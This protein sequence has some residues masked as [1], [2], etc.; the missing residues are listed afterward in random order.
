M[1]KRAALRWALLTIPAVVL[2][3]CR[4]S[5]SPAPSTE[6]RPPAQFLPVALRAGAPALAQRT[7]S[8]WA[9]YDQDREVAIFFRP[10]PGNSDSTEYLRFRV[11]ARSLLRDASGRTFSGSDSVLITIT[12]PDSGVFAA[13]FQPSGLRF[14]PSR[15]A[16]LKFELQERDDDLDRD[17]D[18]DDDDDDRFVN[19]SLWR[20]ERPGS[21][22]E[23]IASLVL[24]GLEEIEAE[25]TG[26]TG[27]A[28]AI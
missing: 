12:V 26:F 9:R 10:Q 20:Q 13:D 7:V 4:E 14:D 3:A 19:L 11:P 22:W 27:Y 23:K 15:P 21:V 5:T 6:T 8:F 18:D 16:R 2:L 17:G 1:R 24:E 25:I 28:V